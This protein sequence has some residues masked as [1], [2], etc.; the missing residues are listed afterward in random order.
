MNTYLQYIQNTINGAYD[1]INK[2]SKNDPFIGGMKVVADNVSVSIDLAQAEI[3]KINIIKA[4]GIMT[5]IMLWDKT[6]KS[7]QEWDMMR[8]KLINFLNK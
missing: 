8:D 5:H 4:E 2:Y 1:Y 6:Q 7:K 3:D